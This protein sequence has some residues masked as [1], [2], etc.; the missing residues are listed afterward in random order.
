VYDYPSGK[1]VDTITDGVDG[2]NGV[3][4]D[5]AAPLSRK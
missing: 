4:L 3:A 5:P 1:L 2:P